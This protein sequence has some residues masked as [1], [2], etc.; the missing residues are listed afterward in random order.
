M[1]AA[2]TRV[3]RA[4]DELPP[5]WAEIDILVNNAG[6]SRGMEKLYT[7]KVEDWEEMIDT[8]IKGCSTWRAHGRNHPDNNWDSKA[9]T[10][11]GCKMSPSSSLHIGGLAIGN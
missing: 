2:V 6:L 4:I 8:N 3:Q 9:T 5:E 10:T 11:S 7:G 1:C